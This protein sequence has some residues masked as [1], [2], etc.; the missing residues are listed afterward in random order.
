MKHLSNLLKKQAEGSIASFGFPVIET[1]AGPVPDGIDQTFDEPEPLDPDPGDDSEE[2]FRKKLLELERRT[3]EIERDAYAKGF[4]QGEKDGIEYGQKAV[5]VIK[6]Q[7]ERIAENLENI[8]ARLFKEYRGWFIITCLK[9]AR[10]VV[11]REL[12]VSPG[13]VARVVSS[14]LEEAEEH[15][16]LTLYLNPLDIEFM[17]KR[18]DLVLG[19]KGKHLT[20]KADSDLERGG[21]RIESEIQLLD[22]SIDGQFEELENHLLKETSPDEPEGMAADGK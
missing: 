14:L 1:D 9:A 22:A 6:S 15:S 10:R 7:L 17:E 4:A 13:I 21:C 5:L 20:I 2:I 18:A 11:R 3:Q 19:T 12:T 8:P 16:S